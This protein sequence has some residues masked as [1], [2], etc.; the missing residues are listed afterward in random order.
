MESAPTSPRDSAS[1]DL[2]TKM[3]TTVIAVSLANT[4][5]FIWTLAGDTTEAL[6]QIKLYL[7]A[8][9]D[10]TADFRDSPNWWFRGISE[11]PRYKSLVGNAR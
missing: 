9:P 7:L 6:N 4:A 5:A 3:I 2:T 11:D 8:N 1:D 10:R